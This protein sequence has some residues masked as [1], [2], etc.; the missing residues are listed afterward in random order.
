MYSTRFFFRG[1]SEPTPA[2]VTELISVVSPRFVKLCKDK[3]STRI[4]YFN[5]RSLLPKID[6]LR[7]ICSVYLP[8]VICVV[9]TWLD[10]NIDDSEIIIQGYC[11]HRVDRNRHGGGILVFIKDVYLFTFV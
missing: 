2:P 8:D 9:E 1:Q 7:I 11:V 10:P 5:V 4:I 6:D 3:H